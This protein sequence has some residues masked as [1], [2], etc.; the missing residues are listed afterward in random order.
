FLS[1][2]FVPQADFLGRRISA[3]FLDPGHGGRD[4]GAIG[5][6]QMNGST[7]VLQE[8]DVV[9]DVSLQVADLLRRNLPGVKVVLSRDQDV[10]LTLEERT[11]LANAIELQENEN[12]LYLSI[13][14]NAAINSRSRG[15][16]VW[17]LPPDYRRQLIAPGDFEVLSDSVIPILNTILEEEITVESILLSQAISESLDTEVGDLSP[18][19]GLFEEEWYVVR[20]A[21]MPSVLVELGFLTN[22]DEFQLLGDSEYLKKLSRGIYTGLVRFLNNFESVR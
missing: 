17:Y 10:Y 4:P 6:H 2:L 3:I 1:N 8:K 16:E 22:A 7:Q 5:R 21:R 12:I 18:N 20:N 11:N 9:L 19:R 13:H 14:A 15:F